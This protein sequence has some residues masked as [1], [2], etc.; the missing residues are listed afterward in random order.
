VTSVPG[1]VGSIPTQSRQLFNNDAISTVIET[2][3]LALIAN[4]LL[5]SFRSVLRKTVKDCR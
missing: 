5:H 3:M 1:Q 4:V 2:V